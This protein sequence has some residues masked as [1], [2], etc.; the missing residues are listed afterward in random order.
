MSRTKRLRMV[1]REHPDLSLVRQAALLG[2][3]RSSLY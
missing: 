2:V 3:S 1:R